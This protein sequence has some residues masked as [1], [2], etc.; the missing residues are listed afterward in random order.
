MIRKLA[1]CCALALFILA[2]ASCQKLAARDNLVKG[3]R[4]FKEGN[5]ARAAEY[6][7]AA[8]K[9][10]PELM[11]A[12]LYLGTAY[13]SQ[14]DPNGVGEENQKLAD[15]AIKTFEG[16]LQKD[17]KNVSAV[18]GLAGLFQGLKNFDKSKEYYKLQT[19]I[20]PNNAVPYYAIAST[21]W[22]VIRDRA[23]RGQPLSDEEKAV[24]V[25]EG[26]QYVDKALE[27]NPSYQEAMAYK[28]LL[29]RDKAT[30]AKD[31]AEAKLLLDEADVWFNKALE[32]LKTNAEKKANS[33]S[34]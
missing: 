19:E 2:T 24:V 34:E 10:D 13:A 14:F 15:N 6:F 31:P 26:L 16:V 5:L 21:D 8:S 33:A 12:Q 17:P 25:E 22:I 29:L 9:Q 18:S 4:A 1:T 3:I 11:D 28:N 27:K 20:D 23:Q 7:D 32:T 30:L